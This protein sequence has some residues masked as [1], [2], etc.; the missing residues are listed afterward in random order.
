MFQM[1]EVVGVSTDSLSEAIRS[2]VD[3]VHKSG[4]KVY[5]FEIMEQ[6]GA[7]RGDKVEFQVKLKVGVAL[8]ASSQSEC[9]AVI[10][11]PSCGK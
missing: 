5:W 7:V 4:E 1:L 8:E 2:A 3:K 11:C 10:C 9:E 6:R